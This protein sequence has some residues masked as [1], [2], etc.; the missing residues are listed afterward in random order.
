MYPTANANDFFRTASQLASNLAT[1]KPLVASRTIEQSLHRELEDPMLNA[2]VSL[3]VETAISGYGALVFCSSRQ[4]SQSTAALISNAISTEVVSSDILDKRMD[5]V[6]SLQ[7][8]PSGFEPT[9]LKTILCGVAFHHAGLTIEERDIVAEAY[10]R[11][12][13]K[14][15]VA[16][17]S[18]AA[19]IN[20][21]ARRVILNGARM[22]RDLVGPAMLRRG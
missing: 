13:L 1:Q 6:A 16:T 17:C 4:G 7:A 18:L 22:G 3:A 5:V 9:F 19:G 14:V 15:M 12:I 8:L 21:P 10:D 2:V 20:L 11:G